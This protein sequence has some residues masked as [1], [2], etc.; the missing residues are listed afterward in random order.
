MAASRVG[1]A[2]GK[3]EDLWRRASRRSAA[4]DRRAMVRAGAHGRTGGCGMWGKEKD[5]DDMWGPH[6]SE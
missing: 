5:G 1:A 3:L 4:A 2:A 6:V